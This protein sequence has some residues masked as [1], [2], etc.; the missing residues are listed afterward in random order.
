[1][2]IFGKPYR[3]KS[4]RTSH[5]ESCHDLKLQNLPPATDLMSRWRVSMILYYSLS[6]GLSTDFRA[7]STWV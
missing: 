1:M 7:C 3:L 6:N 4:T 5:S 2:S